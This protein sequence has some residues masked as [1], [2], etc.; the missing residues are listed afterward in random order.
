MTESRGFLGFLG[1]LGLLRV[2]FR[3]VTNPIHFTPRS[4][5]PPQLC[6]F[7]PSLLHRIGSKVDDDHSRTII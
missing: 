3:L 5:L 1:F 2:V 6:S 7:E 4:S